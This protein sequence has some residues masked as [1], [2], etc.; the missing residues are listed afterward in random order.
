MTSRTAELVEWAWSLKPA[1]LPDDARHALRRHLLDGWGC[2]LAAARLDA[3]APALRVA[4]SST[5]PAEAGVPGSTLRLPVAQAA[6][7]TGALVHAL[8]FDDTHPTGLVH[9]TACVLPVLSAVG[10]LVDADTAEL[11]VAA[12]AGYELVTR[13]GAAVAHGFHARGFHATS[14]CG[15]FAATVVTARLLD[16]SS[17]QAVNALGIAGSAAAGSLEFLDAGVD[18]KALHPALAAQAAVTAA[19][20]AGAGAQGPATILEGRNGLFASYLN[21]P[22]PADL[23]ADL[24]KVWEVTQMDIKPYP[25]CHLSH[26]TIDAA[27]DVSIPATDIARVEIELPSSAM[28]IV[29]EPRE[30]KL[31]PGSSYAAKFSLPWTVAA[32]LVDGAVTVDTFTHVGRR[33]VC[34]LAARVDVVPVAYDAP[35]ATAPGRVRVATQEGYTVDATATAGRLLDDEALTAKFIDNAGGGADAAAFAADLLA[36]GWRNP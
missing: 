21:A 32:Q 34:E 9:A 18:T 10:Q 33:E 2:A 30:P 11:E 27:R 16:L 26:A 7:A 15:V 17:Q 36:N 19:R 3:A 29:A 6:F 24:G 20:L 4:S 13:L 31:T 5:A 8:D 22:A 28:S 23:F 12:V 1:D 14:V 35:P 25:C